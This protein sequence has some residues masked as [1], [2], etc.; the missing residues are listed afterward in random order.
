MQS[1]CG[2]G[3]VWA[4][5]GTGKEHSIKDACQGGWVGSGRLELGASKAAVREIH[6]GQ[7]LIPRMIGPLRR[8][9]YSPSPPNT[10]MPWRRLPPTRANP[11]PAGGG[12]VDVV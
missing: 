12:G 6:G 8:P 10:H 9:L 3:I 2:Q 11:P 1:I 7:D 4:V 5:G